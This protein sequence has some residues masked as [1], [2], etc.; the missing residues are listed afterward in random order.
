ML[1]AVVMATANCV[2]AFLVASVDLGLP[3]PVATE[4]FA[5]PVTDKSAATFQIPV[6]VVAK[7]VSAS[8]AVVEQV[9]KQQ[10]TPRGRFP[11]KDPRN[12][13]QCSAR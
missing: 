5:M 6:V 10:L 11:P 2:V 3:S 12:V 13:T 1:V 7:L 9:S 8:V 4:V